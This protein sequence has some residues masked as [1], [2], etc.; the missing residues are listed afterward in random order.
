MRRDAGMPECTVRN[1]IKHA[2]EIKGK[3]KVASAFCGL[4]TSTR[5]SSLTVIETGLLIV[6]I[7]D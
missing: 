1:I 3:G 6:W 4:H 5:N 2:G 7:E